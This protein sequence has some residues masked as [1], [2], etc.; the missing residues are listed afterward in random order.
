[1]NQRN[2]RESGKEFLHPNIKELK[3]YC[4]VLRNRLAY[5]READ[6]RFFVVTEYASA[7]YLYG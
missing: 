2:A 6:T 1:M 4:A 3:T 7:L 5:P